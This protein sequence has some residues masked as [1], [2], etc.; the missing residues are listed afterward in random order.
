MH[1]PNFLVWVNQMWHR[2]AISRSHQKKLRNH[3][4]LNWMW[5]RFLRSSSLGELTKSYI[6]LTENFVALMYDRTCPHGTVI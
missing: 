4:D 3:G 1:S 6:K 2:V 5:Q